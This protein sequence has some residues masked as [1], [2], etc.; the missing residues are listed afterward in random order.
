K[1]RAAWIPSQILVPVSRADVARLGD[2]AA[3]FARDVR[4][5]PERGADGHCH[6]FT[7]GVLLAPRLAG[8]LVLFGQSGIE[9]PAERD[10]AREAAGGDDEAAPGF[11]VHW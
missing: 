4:C 2:R 1:H 5:S 10:V 8:D 6:R 7:V 9:H 3:M 11:N